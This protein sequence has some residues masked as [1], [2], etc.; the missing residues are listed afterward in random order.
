MIEYPKTCKEVISE[1]VPWVLPIPRVGSRCLYENITYARRALMG[2]V[3]CR[4]IQIQYNMGIVLGDFFI[5]YDLDQ[6]AQSISSWIN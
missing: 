1:L 3:T 5:S 2:L 6:L 4:F